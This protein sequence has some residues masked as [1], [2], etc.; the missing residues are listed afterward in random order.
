MVRKYQRYTK[1]RSLLA[2]GTVLERWLIR[3]VTVSLVALVVTQALMTQD[4]FRFYLSFAERLD[5]QK[6]EESNQLQPV[7]APDKEMGSITL[8]LTNFSAMEKAVI[9]VNG[10]VVADFREKRVTIPVN[11][12]DT[13][14]VDGSFYQYPLAILIQDVSNNVGYPKENQVIKVEQS[15]VNLGRITFIKK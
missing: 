7:L 8:E 2:W 4:P 14:E 11:S 15:R 9:L 13:L 1:E 12:G 5:G 3:F 6:L 10:Q